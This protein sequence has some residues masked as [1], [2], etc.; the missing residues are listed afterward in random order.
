MINFLC[1]AKYFRQGFDRLDLSNAPGRLPGF[2]NDCCQWAARMIG[3]YLKY[4]CQLDP[5]HVCA[6]RR[7]PHAAGGHEWI[8]IDD[9]II[10][11]TPDQFPDQSQ[12]FIV[13]NNS[14][15]HQSWQIGSK[16]KLIF[17]ITRY[18]TSGHQIKISELYEH[19]AKTVRENC[20]A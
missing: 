6:S 8:E 13:S 9:T 14:I 11:I 18:D 16:E 2:P 10:D 3:H 15:W 12:S 20:S 17:P 5:V 4:E 7:P 19:I 1:I